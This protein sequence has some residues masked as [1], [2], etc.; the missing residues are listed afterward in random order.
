MSIRSASYLDS[1]VLCGVLGVEKKSQ[2]P[3]ISVESADP[4]LRNNKIWL[5]TFFKT[6]VIK[7]NVKYWR[8]LLLMDSLN[9]ID[10][11]GPQ[12]LIIRLGLASPTSG[13]CSLQQPPTSS[14]KTE[15]ED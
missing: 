3:L 11:L 1:G 5:E 4:L 8:G 10:L 6:R 12:P 2:G 9:I 7:L 15:A 13:A 14:L